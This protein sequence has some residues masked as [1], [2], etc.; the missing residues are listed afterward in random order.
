MRNKSSLRKYPYKESSERVFLTIDDSLKRSQY[1]TI[2]T[3]NLN[4]NSNSYSKT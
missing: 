1:K 3:L 4:N 2:D